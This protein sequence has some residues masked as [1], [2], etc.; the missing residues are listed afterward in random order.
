MN[1][2]PFDTLAAGYALG[3]LDGADLVEF[4]A[5]LAGGCRACES[6]LRESH[7]ALAAL[8]REGPPIAPPPAIKAALLQRI[9]AETGRR[10]TAPDRWRT[11]TVWA[12][13]LAAGA[14][15]A[16]LVSGAYVAGRYEARIAALTREAEAIRQQVARDEVSLRD[17]AMLSRTLTAVLDD[18]GARVVTLRGQGPMASAT[19]RLL[20]SPA[21]G[22]YLAVSGLHPVPEGRA[23]ELWTI[24]EGTPRPAGVFHPDAAGRALHPVAATEHPVDVFAI[25][26]EP[27]AG[28]QK[29]TG[30]IVLVSP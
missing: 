27:A 22:G 19:G 20:W 9:E 7:Q 23:Y 30:P 2:E 24:R 3:V 13:G 28:V 6:A 12:A 11:W 15:V 29:P 8:A 16:A 25:T 17:L 4:E 18:P 5:H 21:V 26:V 14:V 1:H 10:R